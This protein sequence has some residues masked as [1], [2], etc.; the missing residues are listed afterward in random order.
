MATE[1]NKPA[2]K[3]CNV[4]VIRLDPAVLTHRK[5]RKKNPDHDPRKPCVYVGM[6]HRTPAERLEQHKRGYKACRYPKLYGQALIPRHFERLNPMT[7]ADAEKQEVALAARLRR[8][9]YAVWQ[10]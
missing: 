7:R 4:Y 1:T 3:N 9:G 2:P 6:S 10:N 5:F 8:R